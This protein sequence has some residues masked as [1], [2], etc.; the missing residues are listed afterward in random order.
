MKNLYLL[1]TFIT[2]LSACQNTAYKKTDN[3]II[4]KLKKTDKNDAKLVKIEVV[5]DEVIR[6]IASPKPSI[7]KK[8]SL[9]VIDHENKKTEWQIEENE[10]SISVKTQKITAKI[11]KSTGEIGFLD[12]IGNIILTEKTGGWKKFKPVNIE[13]K[14]SY[15]IQQKFESP[16]DEA[17]YGLG[18]H[19]HNEF[20]Y[21]GKDVE[22][23][24]H[25]IVS[26]VPF[27]VSNKNYGILWDNYSITKFGDDREYEELNS[28]TTY[29]KN[30]KKVGLTATYSSKSDKNKIYYK[31][32]EKRISYQFLDSLQNLPEKFDMADGV[33]TWEGAI[34]SKSSGIHKFLLYSSGYI[35]CWLN[36][37]LVLD[38][39]RQG[40]NPWSRKLFLKMEKDKK[41]PVKLEWIPDG[42]QAFVSVKC[43]SPLDPIEQNRLSLTS[44]VGDII[45][46]YFVYGKT[47]DEIISGYR[48]ITGKA[49]IMPKWAMGYWQSRERYQTS[50]QLL[51]VV[52]EYRNRKIPLD[53]IVLDWQYWEEDKWGSHNF[54]ST[55]FPDPKAMVDKIHNKYNAR[56]MI[57]VWPKFYKGIDNYNL[58]DEKGWLYKN[59]IEQERIDWVG[60]GYQSTFYDAFN[61]DAGKLFWSLINKNLYSKGFDA[62]WLDATEPDMHSNISIKERKLNM[63]PTDLGPGAEYFN[64]Y[65]LMNSKAVFE[66]QMEENPDKRVFILTRSAYAGQ[67]RYSAATWSGDVA[68]RWYDL[69]A[70]ISAGINF[71]ISGIPYWTHDIGG[72]SIENRYYNMSS[73][74]IDEWRE[75]NCRW[76]Q[77]G[78]FTPLFRSHG[79]FPLREIF[80]MAPENHTVYKSMVYYDKLRYRL[81]PY[82]YSLAGMAYHNDYTIMRALVM[83]F[84]DDKLTENIGNQYMFGPHLLI[85]PVYKYKE[86]RKKLYLPATNG[87]YNLYDGD[88]YD[89]GQVVQTMAELSRIPVFVKEGAIIPFGPEIQYADEK[90]AD[91]TTLFVY[92][93][94]NGEFEIYEDENTNNNYLNGDYAIIPIKYNEASKTLTIGKRE[95]KFKGM[96]ETRTFNIVKVSK[97]KPVALD[98][99]I[100]PDEIIVYNGNE[101]IINI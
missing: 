61:V 35:K 23:A 47:Y 65:S 2:V 99:D 81:M 45:D 72:F 4:V 69:E 89:G 83:D 91:P 55:R 57:S 33:V 36:N 78:A 26:V 32:T 18:Q 28:L 94:K 63:H 76:F 96:I 6:I 27:L 51:G 74:D 93:G 88:Y 85:N 48:Y 41:Y 56:I 80:N 16:D 19:Q 37:E 22:L 84:Y 98:F 10:K 60:P 73:A 1:I 42:G 101:V 46:Y 17:F 29:S 44:E 5:S 40:W 77:F 7:R 90:H 53:N 68:C 54:D 31:A 21:K 13:G 64:G 8:N 15:C 71:C 59:N 14:S 79:Q 87:W 34:E 58:F 20:N 82:I 39:W 50:E 3:G 12:S 9:M 95:G 66:G 24:Q 92:T 49:P 38:N 70:Q 11:N 62:W 30:G 43:L 75:L 100:A 52:K 86:R 97:E 25:N 67:Q